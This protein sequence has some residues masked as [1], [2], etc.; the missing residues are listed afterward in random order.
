MPP[1]TV[2]PLSIRVNMGAMILLNIALAL[3]CAWISLRCGR[4]LLS[5]FGPLQPA[6][7]L[8]LAAYLTLSVWLYSQPVDA[9]QLHNEWRTRSG[10]L[11]RGDGNASG[12]NSD[13]QLPQLEKKAA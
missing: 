3:C 2:Y 9:L 6:V 10:K 13:A 1:D 11:A 4:W 7:L 8:A 5:L 12:T